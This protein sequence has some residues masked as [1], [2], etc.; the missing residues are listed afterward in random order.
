MFDQKR[1]KFRDYSI[2]IFASQ[3]RKLIISIESFTAD[4]CERERERGRSLEEKYGIPSQSAR[5]A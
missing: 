3:Y 5:L 1:K 2:G 4:T